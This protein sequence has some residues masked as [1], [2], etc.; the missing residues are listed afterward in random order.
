LVEAGRA[1]LEKE[2]PSVKTW[3]VAT[4]GVSG[5]GGYASYNALKLL[6]ERADLIGLFLS[7]SPFNPTRFSRDVSGVSSTTAH[8]CRSSSAAI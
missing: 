7:V 4:G 1:A 3:P 6:Q 5:G 2:W 8:K